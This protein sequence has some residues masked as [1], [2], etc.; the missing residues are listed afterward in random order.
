MYLNV[1]V[2]EDD[3]PAV[4]ELLLERWRRRAAAP[5]AS[6]L[7]SLAHAADETSTA[8][9]LSGWRAQ[10]YKNMTDVGRTVARTL[11]E[12]TTPWITADDL[13]E[14]SGVPN[15]GAALQSIRIQ[16]RRYGGPAASL[17]EKKRDSQTSRF[18]YSMSDQT[19]ALIKQLASDGGGG[20]GASGE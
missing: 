18:L 15:V 2:H 4:F 5:P 13:Q 7:P 6:A 12:S 20:D 3:L 9:E 10:A 1:P 19:A 14:A 17:V 11:A 16:S 8:E